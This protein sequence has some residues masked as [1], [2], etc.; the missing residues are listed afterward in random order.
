MRRKSV[1]S[2]A[3]A[4]LVIGL[5]APV[6]TAVV[7]KYSQITNVSVEGLFSYNVVQQ[8]YDNPAFVSFK[9]DTVTEFG[10]ASDTISRGLL[11]HND[12]AGE[13]FFRVKVGDVI[14]LRYADGTGGKFL[15]IKLR[16]LQALSPYSTISNFIDL[17]GGE[18]LTA[19]E[20]YYQ[21]YG[22][23]KTLVIQTCI[24]KDKELTW[25]RLFIIAVPIRYP[26]RYNNTGIIP[27]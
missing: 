12:L 22:V 3:I 17:D 19:S 6:G 8:P 27:K 10:T 24:A 16:Y 18:F 26:P 14:S 13:I 20:L 7:E 4:L 21:T 23:G 15:V 25:G 11:A 5:L 2:Y 1:R 9:P